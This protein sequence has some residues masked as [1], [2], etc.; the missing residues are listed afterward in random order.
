[1]IFLSRLRGIRATRHQWLVPVVS[2]IVLYTLGYWIPALCFGIYIK[3]SRVPAD[4]ALHLTLALLVFAVSRRVWAFLL[5]QTLLVGVLY[6]GSAVKTS[7]LGRPIMPED[8]H[9]VNAL[10]RILGPLGWLAVALPLALIISL[11]LFNL[12]LKG[13][14]TKAAW[15]LLIAVPAG[16]SVSL[17]HPTAQWLEHGLDQAFDNFPWDQRE[18]YIHRGGTLNFVQEGV[19]VLA[20]RRPAPSEA[21]VREAV[22]RRQL[23][24][25]AR[26]NLADIYS[27]APL[28]AD[29][30]V[31]TSYRRKR[32]VHIILE[33]SFWDP[34]PLVA[35]HFNQPPLDPRFVA[36][37]RQTGFSRSLSPAYG[38]QTANA[39]FEVLCGL[40]LN[41]GSVKFEY[42]LKNSMP[43]LPN[44][45]DR[46]G[47]RT[48]ASHP[49]IPAFWNRQVAFKLL[50]FETFWAG[51]DFVMD[52]LAG[53]EFLSDH[54]LH[55][56]VAA[57]L[58]ETAASAGDQRPVFDYIVS[59][60][61][62]WPYPPSAQRPPV[63]TSDSAWPDV[64]NYANAVYYKSRDIVDEI[65]RLRRTDPDSVIVVFGDHLPSLGPRFGGYV[66]SGLLKP[67]F[68]E[69]TAADYALSSTPPLIVIDGR[70]GPLRLGHL[71]M[72]R[73][74]RLV[75]DLIGEN[76]PTMFDLAAPPAE[77]KIRP[78]PGV[79]LAY[80][81]NSDNHLC[82]EGEDNQT[83]DCARL[84]AWLDDVM[85]ISRDILIGGR[86]ALDLMGGGAIAGG[87]IDPDQE[88]RPPASAVD[89]GIAR[90]GVPDRDGSA[91]ED[92]TLG[93]RPDT[94][95]PSG[96]R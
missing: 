82:R 61:G 87:S 89:D 38:G 17:T 47:Y 68:G 34:S 83:P 86:Y 55:A 37:W 19:R 90:I 79:M 53:G 40:P 96:S 31:D 10:V 66:E 41:E 12:R 3:P 85:T 69:F 78:L 73:L 25:G 29:G 32:N 56:Q 11:F 28:A 2:T 70:N 50:G 63:I 59:I 52:D 9:N 54:S 64:V 16:A 6:V 23:A 21:E 80:G 13:R 76:G 60:F 1:M 94:T 35:A 75:M 65:E 4:F 39:E 49:N 26:I 46:A 27:P 14:W 36:L 57:K 72:Y 77:A 15:G 48:V 42:G 67:T 18:N 92:S 30:S 5:L 58:T 24:N 51:K 88:R 20:E 95:A 45:L 91:S 7:M 93:F 62:H 71:P 84:T 81:D 33:E 44:L 43:C 8:I 22:A 74:P